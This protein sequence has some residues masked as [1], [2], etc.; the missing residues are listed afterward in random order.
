MTREKM[1]EKLWKLCVHA[2]N[3]RN[4]SKIRGA[5]DL[6]DKWNDA[7]A[8]EREIFMAFDDEWVMVEDDV[9]YFNGAF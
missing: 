3:E 2:V 6:C 8:D 5:S 7:H 1:I 9:V 4:Y